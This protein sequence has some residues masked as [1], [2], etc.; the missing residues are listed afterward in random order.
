MLILTYGSRGDVEPYVA[1]GLGLKA[2]GHDVM[3]ATSR[4][5]QGFVEAHGL[6]FGPLSD[7][8]L[9]ILDTDQGKALLEK[10]GSLLQVIKSSLAMWRQL[11]PMQQALMRECWEVAST[12]RPDIIVYHSKAA[13]APSIAD[14]LGSACVLATPVP[15]HVPT[16]AFRFAILPRL[17]L[18][19]WVNKASYGLTNG[20][21]KRVFGPLIQDFRRSLDLPA[22]KNYDPLTRSDGSDIPVLHG[23]SQVVLPRPEDWPASAHV[24]GYWFLPDAADWTPPDALAAFLAAGPPPVY[25]GFGSMS[26]RQPETLARLSAEALAAAGVRGILASGWGALTAADLPENVLLIQ[27]APHHWLFPK[28]A[29]IVHHGGAGTTAAALQAGKP[30]LVVPFFGDQPFWGARVHAIGAGPKPIPRAKL[31]AARLAAA[32]REM[33]RS[34]GMQARAA[35]IGALISREDGVAVARGLIENA[36][37]GPGRR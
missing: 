3:L 26:V 11:K 18:G 34:Q 9:S 1:L 32:I 30:S 33:T 4:R 36:G 24:T 14:R 5:F 37:S 6:A 7:A 12:F 10:G 17:P 35:E 20:V 28:M 16:R 31:T 29:A 19:G 21:V 25:V 13:A 2:H 15:M 22:V 27:E 23:F 8:L